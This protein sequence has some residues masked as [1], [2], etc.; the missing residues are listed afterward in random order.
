MDPT[1]PQI[2]FPF[3]VKGVTENSSYGTVPEGFALG[4]R[5]VVGF[6][7]LEGRLRGGKRPGTGRAIYTPVDSVGSPVQRMKQVTLDSAEFTDAAG[8][9]DDPFFDIGS[10][11]TGAGFGGGWG[12]PRTDWDFTLNP[13]GPG[14]FGTNGIDP[15]LP[16]VPSPPVIVW[17]ESFPYPTGNLPGNGGWVATWNPE[18]GV[19]GRR[20]RMLAP[21]TW[22]N[23]TQSAQIDPAELADLDV[24]KSFTISFRVFVPET[25]NGT[26]TAQ[27]EQYVASIDFQDSVGTPRLTLSVI[28]QTNAPATTKYVLRVTIPFVINQEYAVTPGNPFTVTAAWDA[29]TGMLDVF[30]DDTLLVS[31][32][33]AS[34]PSSIGRLIALISGGYAPNGGPVGFQP[35]KMDETYIDNIIIRQDSL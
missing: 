28:A 17:L 3:P 16:A 31:I 26:V 20:A 2:S 13:S 19:T 24:S 4:A 34:W 12:F 14:G 15:E 22:I 35:R 27:Y 21:F 29:D 23:S 18:L 10:G 7:V 30:Q 1:R 33:V 5:N 32:A 9:F 25:P 6:D 8:F 11:P